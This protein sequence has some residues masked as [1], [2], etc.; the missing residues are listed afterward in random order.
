MLLLIPLFP[1]LGD[2]TLA[3]F[4]CHAQLLARQWPVGSLLWRR[5][6]LLI[7]P[8]N[9]IMLRR[10]PL[11]CYAHDL[12]LLDN[13]LKVSYRSYLTDCASKSLLLRLA[14]LLW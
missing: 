4:H 8:F 11:G 1:L 6:L 9:S 7:T 10:R 3:S 12:V 2:N 13:Q 14:T 5:S